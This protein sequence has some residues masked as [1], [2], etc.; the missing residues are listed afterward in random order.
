VKKDYY[1][2]IISSCQPAAISET[3]KFL[4]LESD[5]HYSYI[6]V[7]GALPLLHRWLGGVT[8]MTLDLQ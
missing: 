4:C 3:A 5:L 2:T 1:G 6:A 8:V 7:P